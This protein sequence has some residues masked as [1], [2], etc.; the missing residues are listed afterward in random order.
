MKKIIIVLV[1]CFLL[2]GCAKYN[3]KSIVKELDKKINK[4]SGYKVRGNLSVNN[5]DEIYNYD[6]SVDYKK[7][8]LYK[9]TLTNTANEHT[10]IILKNKDGVYVLTPA[11]NKSFRF[12]SE[13]PYNNSQIYLLEAIVRDI[14]EDE[15]RKFKIIDNK[16]VFNTK[17]NYPNNSSLVK[18]KIIFNKNLDVEKVVVYD[19]DNI[20]NMTMI[21]DDIKYNPKFSKDNFSLDSI[22]SSDD[23][24]V[25]TKES[26]VLEDVIYPLFLPNGTKLIDEEKVTKPNGERVIMTYDGEKSFLLVEETADV[27]NEFTII[28]SSG[29]PFRLMD[30]LGVITDNSLSWT[31]G[32]T[33]FYLVSDMMSQDEM[34]EIA[35]SIG[36]VPSLK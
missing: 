25:D 1:F 30:T 9:V 28:P 13:W 34:I 36:G 20:D 14:R 4:S 10:Q 16:Y 17:V 26:S 5:N 31:S 23:V 21:F 35:Q 3:Q 15:N 2:T 22:V 7:D 24:D 6:V 12:Q 27:F 32:D 18:Q 11:L 33:D 19:K 29:E 8:N